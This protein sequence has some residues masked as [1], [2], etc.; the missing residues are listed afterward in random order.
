MEIQVRK[1][2]DQ[3]L[4][5]F[6]VGGQA[7]PTLY[8]NEDSNLFIGHTVKAVRVCLLKSLYDR[9]YVSRSLC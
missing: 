2:I 7:I 9:I 4:P 3:V 8:D 1:L 5:C 6:V